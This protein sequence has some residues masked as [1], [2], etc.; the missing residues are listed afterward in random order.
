MHDVTAHYLHDVGLVFVLQ[1]ALRLIYLGKESS[2]WVG[3]S[4]SWRS[5]DLG[6]PNRHNQRPH[7]DKGPRAVL[8]DLGVAGASRL[9]T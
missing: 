2:C 5:C 3:R 1:E 7:L 4:W 6:P 8:Q 9:P